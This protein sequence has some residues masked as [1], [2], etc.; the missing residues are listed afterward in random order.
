M[1]REAS[2]DDGANAP[3]EGCSVVQSTSGTVDG[4]QIAHFDGE[5]GGRWGADG[6][7]RWLHRYNAARVP[8]IRDAACAAFG[9]DP[10]APDPLRDLRILDIGCGAGILCEPLAQLGATVVGADPAEHTIRAAAVRAEQLGLDVDYRS[11]TAEVLAAAGERFDV[12]LAMEV[13]EH[14]ADHRLFLQTCAA[15]TAPNGLVILSTI[16]RTL[17]SW[18]Q[19]IV[20]GEHVLRLLPRGAHQWDRFV[21]PDEVRDEMGRTGMRV[22]NVSGITM[23]MRTRAMQLS[24]KDGVNYILT[25]QRCGD[26]LLR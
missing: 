22:T 9:R 8:Y 16:N 5:A 2:P 4:A 11:D 15:L 19:A 23:N 6:P 3:V 13:I 1:R 25:A 26:A 20:M 18:V 24:H 12:V 21:K 10:H 7:A 17:K 14:V